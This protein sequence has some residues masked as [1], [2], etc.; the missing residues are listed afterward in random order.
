YQRVAY[1]CTTIHFGNSPFNRCKQI[2]L[3][4]H[5][6]AG[7]YHLPETEVLDSQEIGPV[8]F[9]IGYRVK[10]Q[11][12]TDLRHGFNLKH[13]R[14]HWVP[15]KVALEKRFIYRN[16]FHAGYTFSVQV[17][18]LVNKQEWITMLQD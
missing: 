17:N 5:C 16:V 18:D 15:R 10:H 7:K 2:T 6:I 9:R 8:V 12:T 13:A 4:H 3:N 1:K 11:Y 14:H